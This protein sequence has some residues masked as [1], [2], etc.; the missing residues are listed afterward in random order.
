MLG[1]KRLFFLDMDK[2]DYLGLPV[3][4]TVPSVL[5]GIYEEENI[6]FFGF[7][8]KTDNGY[9]YADLILR[10]P[11]EM[12]KLYGM[13]LDRTLNHIADILYIGNTLK[14]GYP[15]LR[16]SPKRKRE[17]EFVKLIKI[18]PGPLISRVSFFHY[19]FFLRSLY[20]G[21]E[22]K[23]KREMVRIKG[24]VKWLIHSGQ[25][26]FVTPQKKEMRDLLIT[27]PGDNKFIRLPEEL[28]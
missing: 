13:I 6:P 16:I 24:D 15:T 19:T 28:I 3:S 5:R 10:T 18:L 27:Y 17:F 20:F 23:R 4:V 22:Q 2:H 25:I 11:S 26:V 8:F 12:I 1:D 7:F 21:S 9:H 14:R